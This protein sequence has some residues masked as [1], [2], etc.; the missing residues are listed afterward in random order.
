M[1]ASHRFSGGKSCSSLEDRRSTIRPGFTG[2]S[3]D[4]ISRRSFLDA[5]V[6]SQVPV[7]PLAR[8]QLNPPLLILLSLSF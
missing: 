6:E 8:M 3:P 7:N 2:Q 1:W 5:T 4:F